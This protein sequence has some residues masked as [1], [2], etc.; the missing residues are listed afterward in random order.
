MEVSDIILGLLI[1]LLVGWTMMVAIEQR[2]MKVEL[3]ALSV[4]Q[5]AQGVNVSPE[6][7]RQLA[8]YSLVSASQLQEKDYFT[9]VGF[10]PD[11][12][13]AYLCFYE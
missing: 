13:Q 12:N 6:G 2:S 11:S 3:N 1:I 7:C 10:D 9:T 8:G 5:R 4:K